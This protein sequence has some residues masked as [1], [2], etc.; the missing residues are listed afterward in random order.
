MPKEQREVFALGELVLFLAAWALCILAAVSDHGDQG[1]S[2][3]RNS[4]ASSPDFSD[5]QELLE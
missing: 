1:H 5:V 3:A 4:V 2:A